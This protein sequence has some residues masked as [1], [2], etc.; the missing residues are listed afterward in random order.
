MDVK[1]IRVPATLVCLVMLS[2][3][4]HD[5]KT[6]QPQAQPPAPEPSSSSL[7]EPGYVEPTP[8]VPTHVD[9][10]VSAAS[11][12]PYE[13]V[14]PATDYSL[15][16]KLVSPGAKG[17]SST[18]LIEYGPGCNQTAV[19][20]VSE[21]SDAVRLRVVRHGPASRLMCRTLRTASVPLDQ[22]L[23]ER[24]LLHAATTNR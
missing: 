11:R 20:Q 7:P 23:G 6:T 4:T 22:P 15:R 5:A 24:R 18:L 13:G 14:L 21:T 10:T 8:Y 12:E 9:R 2:S 19:V 3:C 17:S 16:W 1:L